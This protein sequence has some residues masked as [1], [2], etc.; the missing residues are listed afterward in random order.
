L[1]SREDFQNNY[2]VIL[3]YGSVD[4]F[5]GFHTMATGTNIGL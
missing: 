2:N 3:A 4:N 5:T 1:E